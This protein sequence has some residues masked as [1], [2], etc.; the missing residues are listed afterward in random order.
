VQLRVVTF[1]IRNGIA[2][3]RNS[4]WWLRRPHTLALLASIGADVVG[5]QEAYVFQERWLARRL[6]V[7]D[8]V[9]E[10][11]GGFLGGERS[12]VLLRQP[13]R[14][15]EHRTLKYHAE[16]PRVATVCELAGGIVI[17]NTHLDERSP[18][19]RRDALVEL[20]ALLPRDRPV[21]VMGDLNAPPGAPELGPLS[22]LQ[23]VKV[24]GGTA[25]SF[26]GGDKGRQ[27]DHVYVSEHWEVSHAEVVRTPRPPWPSDHWPVVVDLR[28]L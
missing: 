21:I 12:P 13:A 5:L 11:R 16:R 23:D 25:H 2:V 19:A 7:D 10:G 26:H 15:V 9:G 3:D 20:D 1:N 18:G 24:H 8:A 4:F 22:W 17:A 6:R 14:L 28:L 27:L